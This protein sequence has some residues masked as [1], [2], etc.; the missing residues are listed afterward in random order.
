MD[1][2]EENP[3]LDYRWKVEAQ[4]VVTAGYS[5]EEGAQHLFPRD[6]A[7]GAPDAPEGGKA[8]DPVVLVRLTLTV[9]HVPEGSDETEEMRVV[10]FVPA[11]PEEKG[12]EGGR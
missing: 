4:D 10:A 9:S 5:G 2:G 3:F 8:P 12:Q 11:P 7:G 1:Y 6:E